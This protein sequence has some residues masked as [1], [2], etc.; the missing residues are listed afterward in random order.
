MQNG[1]HTPMC[2]NES[3]AYPSI[4]TTSVLH[5]DPAYDVAVKL[6]WKSFVFFFTVKA[7][8][9]FRGWKI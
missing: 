1:I 8:L 5:K 6:V 4:Q 3:A 2:T 9:Y 7:A